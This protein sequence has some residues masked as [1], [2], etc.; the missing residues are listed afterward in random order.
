M[1]VQPVGVSPSLAQALNRAGERNGVDFGFLLNTAMRESGMDA[2]AKAP[3]SSAVG[4][5]QFLEQTWF[6]VMKSDG[7]RLG[8]GRYADAIVDNGRGQLTVSDPGL[9]A[10]ILKLRENPDVAADLAAAFTRRNG[11]YLQSRYGRMPSPGELYIAH[12]LGAQGAA[13]LFD[14]GLSNPDQVAA[15]LF[16]DAAASNRAIFFDA[17]GHARTIREVYRALVARHDQPQPAAGF[18]AQQLVSGP[19]PAGAGGPQP[20]GPLVP[21]SLPV[22]FTGLFSTGT[23]TSS[24]LSPV[25]QPQGGGA[26]FTGLYKR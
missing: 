26:F 17:D 21:Q 25:P 9:R 22:D 4:L 13:K 10:E 24:P 8:Y 2:G 11:E 12:F 23:A 5:F 19:P 16:P 15:R 1:A 3:G 20:S 14:A 18:A 7:A 6:S